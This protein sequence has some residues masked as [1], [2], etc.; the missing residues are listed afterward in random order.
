MERGDLRTPRCITSVRRLLS[1]AVAAG[2]APGASAAW[3]RGGVLEGEV[4]VGR[5]KV[6]PAPAATGPGVLYDLASLTKPLVVV[7]LFLLARRAGLVNLH[8][9]VADVLPELGG[10]PVGRLPMERL[11]T[12][13]AG[14]PAWLPLYALCRG[15]RDRLVDALRG[16]VPEPEG[17]V[18]YSCVG[19]VMA[20]LVIERVLGM[21][22]E[23]VFRTRIAAPLGLADEL[24]Y[25][26]D[27]G[28]HAV[29][30]GSEA[31]LAETALLRSLGMED[32]V[33]FI[34]PQ[35]AGEPDDG[36][37]RFLRGVAGN[38]GLFGTAR[39]VLALASQFLAGSSRLFAPEEIELA[40]RNRTPGRAQDRGLGWQLASSPGCSAGPA[41][42][43]SSVGHNGFTGTSVW[44][45]PK[46]GC[47]AVLL[48][49]RHHPAHRD[50]ELHPLRRRFNT[51]VA[52]CM[53][54]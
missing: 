33:G 32:A 17:D 22:L 37:A 30:G 44:V 21:P 19:Y 34:P 9:A 28:R 24:M 47:I 11:L 2:L 54:G 3:G 20:G 14:L 12:H 38:S 18:V 45:D 13:T 46:S 36:N 8:T 27:P 42:S 31:P 41:L 6:R 50:I 52:R 40:V 53:T 16:V 35:G 48:T 49:N 5:A 15:E 26:P 23:D 51:L 4:A 29:A 43:P 39:A 25:R 7:P 10:A 1:R